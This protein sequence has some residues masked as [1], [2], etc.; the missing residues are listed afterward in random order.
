MF[1][2]QRNALQI[3]GVTFGLTTTHV[4][5]AYPPPSPNEANLCFQLLSLESSGLNLQSKEFTR[6]IFETKNLPGW[7]RRGALSQM[8]YF[9][10][11]ETHRYSVTVPEEKF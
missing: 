1:F 7:P 4:H 11:S 5:A 10:D 8:F 6:K 2:N 9:H 3:V